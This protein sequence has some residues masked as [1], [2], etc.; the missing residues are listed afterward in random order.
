M[1][2]TL[3]MGT[4]DVGT[5]SY[6]GWEECIRISN[7]VVELVATT[8]V[9]PRIVHFGF[10]DGG[11]ELFVLDDDAGQTGGEEWHLY[12]G[13]RLWHAPEDDTRTTVP[14]NEPIEYELTE[15]GC[16]LTQPT[17]AATGMRKEVVVSMA[18][19]E[20]MVEV[21]HRLSNE[22][23]WPVEFAPW[24]ITVVEPGGTAI[25]PLPAG[26]Q[27]QLL[28]D[29][30]LTLWPYT[31]PGDDRLAWLDEHLLVH[32]GDGEKLKIGASGNAGWTAYVNDGHALVKAFDWEPDAT[33]PDMGSAVEV[34]TLPF[35]LELETLAPMRSIEP[36]ETAE[37]VESWTLLDDVSIPETSAEVE[38][39]GFEP[40]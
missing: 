22:G 7:G 33:Y 2:D 15:D 8:V 9:G 4:I 36:G 40:E 6:A 37:H 35:M 18:P 11:N 16:I 17:E 14:D 10:V 19:D 21:T 3:T 29:K 23:V 30:S 32:Q 27:E 12:G 13:H 31:S 20:P 38:G 25:V 39:S 34:F 1:E 26:D 28:P 5:V 24:A